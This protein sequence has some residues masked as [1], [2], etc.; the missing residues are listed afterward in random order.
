MESKRGYSV[1]IALKKL[2]NFSLKLNF[3]SSGQ[4][5]AEIV[6]QLLNSNPV[7]LATTAPSGDRHAAVVIGFEGIEGEE[8]LGVERNNIN[9]FIRDELLALNQRLGAYK[10]GFYR[11]VKLIQRQIVEIKEGGRSVKNQ[12]YLVRSDG[13]EIKLR[14][15]FFTKSHKK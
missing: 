8:I 1:S 9:F 13:V 15:V 3:I 4:I 6:A 11:K 7:V 2:K 12:F 14:K 10:D 5:Q